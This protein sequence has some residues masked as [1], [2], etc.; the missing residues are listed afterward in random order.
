MSYK[1]R[2]VFSGVTTAQVMPGNFHDAAKEFGRAKDV[3]RILSIK[4]DTLYNAAK[5]GLGRGLK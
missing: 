2:K 5:L 1:Q 4:R 3:E